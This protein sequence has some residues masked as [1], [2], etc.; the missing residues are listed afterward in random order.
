MEFTADYEMLQDGRVRWQDDAEHDKFNTRMRDERFTFDEVYTLCNG[1][2]LLERNETTQALW[3][4]ARVRW[5]KLVLAWNAVRG[6]HIVKENDVEKD[7]EE[8]DEEE[9]E[10]EDDNS[11]KQNSKDKSKDQKDSGKNGEGKEKTASETSNYREK[12]TAIGFVA[13]CY[14][15]ASL[16]DIFAHLGK[17]RLK[18]LFTLHEINV[19][20][21]V[22]CY[23][24]QHSVPILIQCGAKNPVEMPPYYPPAW[25]Q[26]FNNQYDKCTWW[27]CYMTYERLRGWQHVLQNPQKTCLNPAQN[28]GKQE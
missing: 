25:E 12:V 14:F 16:S 7:E 9:E 27:V 24:N 10:E 17:E 11:N 2:A 5:E 8:E 22:C 3:R 28:V 6:K 26:W 18:T 20:N 15:F 21:A 13:V 4:N 1:D 19:L 23:N